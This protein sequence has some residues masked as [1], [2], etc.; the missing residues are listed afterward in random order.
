M[1][2]RLVQALVGPP[3]EGLDGGVLGSQHR[4]PHADRDGE[5]DRTR[6]DRVVGDRR[7]EPL[8]GPARVR[9]AAA[10][11]Q[12]ELLPAVAAQ[13][14]LGAGEPVQP[15]R[16]DL[17]HLVAD[18]VPV[19]VVDRLEVVD[20]D[21]DRDQPVAV[22]AGHQVGLFTGPLYEFVKALDAIH[23]A[24]ALTRRGVPAEERRLCRGRLRRQRAVTLT[25]LH[26]CSGCL[27]ESN[28]AF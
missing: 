8:G 28:S 23:L 27:R 17:D 5:R 3:E 14:V 16:H 10:H 26:A 22:A 6:R 25:T 13:Q 15:G 12:R 4:G 9:P 19:L 11:Q 2:A 24:K 7:P 20:V 18:L 1:A 21:H